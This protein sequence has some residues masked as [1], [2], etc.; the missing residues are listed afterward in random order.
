MLTAA[1][2][3]T[4]LIAYQQVREHR[5]SK[6]LSTRFLWQSLKQALRFSF[7]QRSETETH[8]T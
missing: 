7:T 2:D 3:M 1:S 8:T 6:Q 4:A 5:F